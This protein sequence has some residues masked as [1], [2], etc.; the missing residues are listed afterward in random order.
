MP[1]AALPCMAL[2]AWPRL[3]S[4]S[5]PLLASR[6]GRQQP[7]AMHRFPAAAL[8]ILTTTAAAASPSPAP[9]PPFVGPCSYKAGFDCDGQ[10]MKKVSGKNMT[11]EACCALC[12][13]TDACKVAVLATDWTNPAGKKMNLC[14]LKSGC[15]NA[16]K[17]N[18][19]GRV[20]CCLPG[21]TA[22]DGCAA[23]P[24]PAAWQCKKD[25]LP[26]F[27]DHTK[28][29]DVRVAELVSAMTP[30]EK[31][32][33]VGQNGAPG[34]ERL[35]IPAYQWWG[36]AQ[37]GVCSSPSVNFRAPT[38]FGTSFPEPGLT[39]ATFDKELFSEIGDIIGKEGRAMANAVNLMF[40]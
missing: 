12:K 8:L 39:G 17:W 19:G 21:S 3:A 31:I 35:S 7:P 37:H 38:P 32:A 23:P 20:K 26:T 14:E 4:E 9:P 16:K 40:K 15:K 29:I 6:G 11:Q 18:G 2:E 25:V 10:D 28:P 30:E 5:E 27:C 1:A 33:Q 24:P 22:A 34:I 13:K 36:E